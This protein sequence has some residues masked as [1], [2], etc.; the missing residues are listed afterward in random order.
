VPENT[1]ATT[2]N[3]QVSGDEQLFEEFFRIALMGSATA[4]LGTKADVLVRR[5]EE[6][7]LAATARTI[8]RRGVR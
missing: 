6:V 1:E 3:N 8:R 5:A 7:A 4:P 2:E